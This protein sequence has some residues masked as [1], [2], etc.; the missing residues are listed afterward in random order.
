MT[1]ASGLKFLDW[2]GFLKM[3]TVKPERRE[4]ERKGYSAHLKRTYTEV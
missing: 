4:E 1:K 2:D 3:Y